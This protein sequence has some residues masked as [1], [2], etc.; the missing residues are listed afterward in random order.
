M[1]R[2][3]WGA[4]DDLEGSESVDL[5]LTSLIDVVLVLLIIFMV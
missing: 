2:V 4:V 5:N 3:D 1:A